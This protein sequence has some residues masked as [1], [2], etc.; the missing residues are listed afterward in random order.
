MSQQ[1]KS[2][3]TMKGEQPTLDASKLLQKRSYK[4]FSKTQ[5]GKLVFFERLLFFAFSGH[6]VLDQLLEIEE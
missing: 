4:E 5:V 3:A 6:P 1:K 2:D